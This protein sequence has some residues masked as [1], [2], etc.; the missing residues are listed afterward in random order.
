[1]N[2]LCCPTYTHRL[3]TE[4]FVPSSSQ[5][6]A[7]KKFQNYLEG[8]TSNFNS[9]HK[10]CKTGGPLFSERK[11]SSSFKAKERV[12]DDIKLI[13]NRLLKDLLKQWCTETNEDRVRFLSSERVVFKLSPRQKKTLPSSVFL[14]SPICIRLFHILRSDGTDSKWTSA[15]DIAESFCEIFEKEKETSFQDRF[16][17]YEQKEWRKWIQNTTLTQS[18]AHLNFHRQHKTSKLPF[19]RCFVEEAY[20]NSLF[21]SS[22]SQ[23][24]HFNQQTT[25]LPQSFLQRSDQKRRWNMS[26]AP[27]V[28]DEEEFQLYQ[29]YQQIIHKD[30]GASLT[31]GRFCHFLVDTPLR[32]IPPGGNIPAPGF[33]T[34]HLQYRID[35]RLV[36]VSVVDV[37]PRCLNSIYFFWDPE[38]AALSLGKISILKEIEWVRSVHKRCPS[39]QY[40]YLGYY[41]HSCSKTRYKGDFGPAELLCPERYLWVELTS[42]VKRV[43]DQGPY[44][45]LSTLAGAICRSNHVFG[46]ANDGLNAP[47]EQQIVQIHQRKLSIGNYLSE[48][49]RKPLT[50]AQRKSIQD[51]VEEVRAW[52]AQTL[53]VAN[54]LTY[55]SFFDC[56][57]YY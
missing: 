31:P 40:Y 19:F 52:R 2:L 16:S 53:L 1:M 3:N 7:L 6:R 34:F 48:M 39:L 9:E 17:E 28:F 50:P 49:S 20:S 44:S 41:V 18:K 22:T 37:L 24:P 55:T 57:S 38:F 5:K 10:D 21:Q 13:F 43:L 33:G 4:T 23:R 56:M 51:F 54:Q 14:T 35:G 15:E 8:E 26:W 45:V 12:L 11:K 47:I 29:R 25:E 32:T 27:S 46:I 36:G 42:E 30:D